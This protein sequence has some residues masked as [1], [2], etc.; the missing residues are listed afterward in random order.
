M[1]GKQ[2]ITSISRQDPASG[3]RSELS[4]IPTTPSSEWGEQM[5]SHGAV[6]YGYSPLSFLLPHLN[7]PHSV[8]SSVQPMLY[9]NVGE[10]QWV[11]QSLRREE[12]TAAYPGMRVRTSPV[13]PPAPWKLPNLLRSPSTERV[14]PGFQIQN[15][16][17][18]KSIKTSR[19]LCC[20]CTHQHN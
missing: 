17:R 9:R 5:S 3:L 6:Q 10:T 7:S 8:P 2:E 13:H 18:H 4:S 19:D 1:G 16:N 11:R 14:V 15:Q 20:L 12:W